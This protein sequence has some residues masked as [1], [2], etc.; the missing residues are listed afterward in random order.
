[1]PRILVVD[2]VPENR[3]LLVTLLRG[4]GF[5]VVTAANGLEALEKARL[6]PP[7]LV[8]TDILMPE[9]DGFALCRAWR[10][11]PVLRSRPFVIYT[12]TYTDPADERLALSLGAD[13]FIL[14]PQRSDELLATLHELLAKGHESRGQERPET[15]LDDADLY[16]M[17][18]AALM[19]KLEKKIAE[20]AEQTRRLQ[21][22]RAQLLAT[23]AFWSQAFDAMPDAMAVIASDGTIL[24]ANRA[25]QE[26][27]G[28]A[29]PDSVVGKKCYTLVHGTECF[30]KDC[31]LVKARENV[32]PADVDMT[33]RGKVFRVE[34]GH[35]EVGAL[36]GRAFIH[37]MRDV[38]SER[39]AQQRLRESEHRLSLIARNLSD[40][41]F[42]ADL[43]G[44]VTFCT[45]SVERVLGWS[46]TEMIGKRVHDIFAPETIALIQ[47]EAQPAFLALAEGRPLPRE[48]ATITFRHQRRD[49]SWVWLEMRA[50]LLR[51]EN[52]VPIGFQGVLQ[53]VDRRH[54]IEEKLAATT[55]FLDSII[56]H[57]PDMIVVKDAAT[58]Q[59]VRCNRA[60]ERLLG[61]PRSELLGKTDADIFSP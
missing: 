32:G 17:H 11:D 54:A 14:K 19:R 33:V 15:K 43:D 52:G 59:W 8:L 61:K 18:T 42:A 20:L 35:L 34:V 56:E 25:M 51:D 24:R 2:D 23:E 9:M 44:V 55:T 1:M 27:C 13:R 48:A 22:T 60:T 49:G 41:I 10:Q 30:V 37:T 47:K 12:A 5:D 58:L 29:W 53:N 28:T 36:S 38:S 16:K 50:G 6:D 7:D 26:V 57:I 3:Y 39:E 31:P 40:V 45:P 46:A 4:H 21:E